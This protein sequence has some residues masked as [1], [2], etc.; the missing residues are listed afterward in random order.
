MMMSGM[1][2]MVLA[3]GGGGGNEL[4]DYIPTKVYWQIESVACTP[5]AMLAQLQG[6]GPVGDVAALVRDLDARSA[7]VREQAHRKLL[8][9][10]PAVIPLLEP[11]AKHPSPEVATRVQEIIARLSSQAERKSIRR[12]MAI[13]ALGEMKHRPAAAAL[14][15][16]TAS[17]E[18]FVADY[19]R[20][21]LA[22]IEGRPYTRPPASAAERLKDVWLLPRT[23]AVVGQAVVPGGA[24]PVDFDKMAAMMAQGPMEIS[25]EQ[26][27]EQVFQKGLLPAVYKVGNLRM[28][29]VTVGVSG[30]MGG[31]AGYVA[32]IGRGKYDARKLRALLRAECPTQTTP[33]AAK[34]RRRR[35]WYK[36]GQVEVFCPDDEV[37]L[38]FPS[39][40]LAVMVAGPRGKGLPIEA[41]ARAVQ[42]G[43][44]D[45]SDNAEMVA[46]IGAAD[47][48]G[49]IWAAAKMTETYRKEELF[50]PFGSMTFAGRRAKGAMAFKLSAKVQDA[51]KLPPTMK[52]VQDALAKARKELAREAQRMPAIKPI[53]DFIQSIQIKQTPQEVTATAQ[54]KGDSPTGLMLMPWLM[55][56]VG[57][58]AMVADEAAA[59]PV[60]VAP[61]RARA[62]P[63]TRPARA[64]RARLAPVERD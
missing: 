61:V 36:V 33:E 44:G 32:V 20:R 30:D 19:A 41:V 57:T 9:M 45:L 39:D 26:L 25:K 6:P 2:S 13:R 55:F 53:A 17:K 29:L 16:L 64:K 46:L 8:A 37:A 51:Q 34:K 18:L 24:K 38:M 42:A 4:L 3:L 12:L 43:R 22:A 50:A 49:M 31:R 15:K 11:H 1:F 28:D 58:R 35:C 56:A 23:C 59:Q 47:K 62:V 52:M 21:A 63:A 5:E 27:I 54:L 40:E 60:P 7:K 14:K 48:S 10:G